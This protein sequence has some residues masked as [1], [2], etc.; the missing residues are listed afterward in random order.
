MNI[1]EKLHNQCLAILDDKIVRMR[2]S[3]ASIEEARN[4][5]TKS[6]AGDKYETTRSMLHLEEEK[7]KSQLNRI[8]E[9][10]MIL[11]SIDWKLK[12]VL[13][14][15]GSLVITTQGKYYISA[16]MGKIGL[17]NETYY[18]ISMSSPIG[19]KLRGK[20]ISDFVNHGDRSF[21]ILEIH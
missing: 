10:K 5:E 21:E 19:Q 8:I 7:N 13:V 1:K 9:Q 11:Q 16:P 4:N 14:G 3:I 2:E 12:K 18:C 15:I 20:N 6:S 17:E